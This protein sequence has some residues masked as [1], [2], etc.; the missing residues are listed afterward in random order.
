MM[1]TG[2]AGLMARI[3]RKAS[4]PSMRAMRT[5]MRMASKGWTSTAATAATPSSASVQSQPQSANS[6]QSV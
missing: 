5:S 2:M 3:R 1:I 4:I 6:E